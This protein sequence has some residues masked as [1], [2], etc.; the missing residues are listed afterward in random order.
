MESGDR[1]PLKGHLLSRLDA[2]QISTSL[3][4]TY[5][6]NLE[7]MHS[8]CY[9]L[10]GSWKLHAGLKTYRAMEGRITGVHSEVPSTTHWLGDFGKVTKFV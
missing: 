1:W 5:V 3:P 9:S 4:L 6:M 2:T 10:W 8:H 7:T